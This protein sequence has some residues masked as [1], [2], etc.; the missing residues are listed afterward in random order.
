MKLSYKVKDRESAYER[1]SVLYEKIQY[2]RSNLSGLMFVIG[3]LSTPWLMIMLSI[4]D[5]KLRPFG[6]SFSVN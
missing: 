2:A 5:T 3:Y 6:I 1:E 4:P